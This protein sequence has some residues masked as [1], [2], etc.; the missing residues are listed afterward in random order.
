MTGR[1]V[2][3]WN[4]DLAPI[5]SGS[6][7]IVWKARNQ[8]GQCA[9]IKE[10]QTE[11]LSQKLLSSLESEVAVLRQTNSKNIVGL[12]DLIQ[13]GTFAR[14]LLSFFALA[15]QVSTHLPLQEPGR[16]FLVL[17]FCGGGDLGQYIRR[18]GRV[19]ENTA[20]Y[21]MHQLAQGLRDLRHLNVI[22]VSRTHSTPMRPTYSPHAL[23]S[24][25]INQHG[26]RI[27]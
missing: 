15:H 27:R 17:E 18:Y 24:H 14:L 1:N 3:P 19:S 26:P 12:I 6:F 25:A 23:N 9:A 7:A 10:I 21:F 16:V 11:R 4:L 5:G 13:A 20:R 2:G 22:H 8:G